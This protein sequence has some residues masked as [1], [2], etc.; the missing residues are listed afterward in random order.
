MPDIKLD[1]GE[2]LKKVSMFA[3]LAEP[4]LRFL[5]ERA[6]AR[7]FA[8]G[9]AVFGE[10][11]PCAGLY[12]IESGHVR[13]FKSSAGGREQ[14]LSIEGPGGSIAE[15]PVFDGGNYPASAVAIDQV[16]L[17]FVSKQDFQ[18]LCLEYPAV[19]LKV[20][21]VVGARLRHLVGIIEELSFTTVRHRLASFLLRVAQREGKRTTAGVEIV[22]T[23]SNQELA[24]QIGTVRELVS[25]NLSRLQTEGILKIDGRTVIVR[26]LSDL[27]AETHSSE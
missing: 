2:T 10:G 23:V 6:I 3:G 27:E 24:S 7:S 19:A 12:V 9:Q 13:I 20:L 21:G 14:V 4:E 17:L 18:A 8:A 26:N 1:R 11:A 5:S 22:L 25:R 15:L 16:T